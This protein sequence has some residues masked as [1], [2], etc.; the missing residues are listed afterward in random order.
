MSV[1]IEVLDY[2][3]E[4][5]NIKNRYGNLFTWN[6]NGLTRWNLATGI[7]TTADGVAVT[8]NSSPSASYNQINC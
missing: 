3:Y 4:Q 8:I 1:Q 6:V 2:D 7:T 5:G